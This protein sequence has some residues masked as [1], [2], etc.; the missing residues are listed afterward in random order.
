MHSS[1]L[2]GTDLSEYAKDSV[3]VLSKRPRSD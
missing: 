1:D 3:N 2:K